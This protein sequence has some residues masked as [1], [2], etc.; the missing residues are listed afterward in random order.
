MIKKPHTHLIE[1]TEKQL[2]IIT[3]YVEITHRAIIN[4]WHDILKKVA[5]KRGKRF[6]W[7]QCCELEKIIENF[8]ANLE[9]ETDQDL[10]KY[11]DLQDT[12]AYQIYRDILE[13]FEGEWHKKNPNQTGLMK[14]VYFWKSDHD[15]EEPKLI[16]K[17]K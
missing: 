1:L 10:L 8:I 15:T 9:D 7:N 2:E 3:E 5:E 14:S 12:D 16:I 17:K 4:Q 13:Y 11:K 6:G